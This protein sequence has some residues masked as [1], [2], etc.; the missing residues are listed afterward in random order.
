MFKENDVQSSVVKRDKCMYDAN[1]SQTLERILQRIINKYNQVLRAFGGND[2]E[3]EHTSTKK[4]SG[5]GGLVTKRPNGMRGR[6]GGARLI[7]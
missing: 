5:R 6:C 7:G 4:S 3:V 2:F 1:D